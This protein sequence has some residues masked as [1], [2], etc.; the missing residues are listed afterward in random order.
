M[1]DVV[2]SARGEAPAE[3]KP[4]RPLPSWLIT[5]GSLVGLLG[6]WEILGRD[7][8]PVFGSH[9]SAIAEAFWQLARTGQPWTAVLDS[10]RA[11][12]LGYGLALVVGMPIRVVTGRL[13]AVEAA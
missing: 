10:L 4:R 12:L 13:P 6:A 11:F 3:A 1:V 5:I 8:N 2:E 9:P 7:I